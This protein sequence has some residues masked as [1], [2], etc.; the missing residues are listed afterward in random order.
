MVL[1]VLPR[2]HQVNSWSNDDGMNLA[3]NVWFKHMFNHQPKECKLAP[4][5]ATLD[6]YKFSDLEQQKNAGKSNE[7]GPSFL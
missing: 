3:V 7:K 4:A 6:K 1:F 2:F 5:D